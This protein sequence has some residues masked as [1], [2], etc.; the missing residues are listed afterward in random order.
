MVTLCIE[1]DDPRDLRSVDDPEI[2][3]TDCTVNPTLTL[4]REGGINFFRILV[5]KIIKFVAE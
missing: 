5:C 4:R 2:G 3:P 1:V